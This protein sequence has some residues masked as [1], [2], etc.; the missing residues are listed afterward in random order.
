MTQPE[1]A[2]VQ[3]SL[4]GDREAFEELVRR[5]GR[6]VF[7]R[8]FLETGDAHLSEDLTQE[9]FLTAYRSIRQVTDVRGFRAWLLSIAHSVVIDNIRRRSRKKRGGATAG[10]ELLK[11]VPDPRDGP[12]DLAENHDERQR[13]LSVLRS[14]PEEYRLPLTLRYIGGADYESITRQLAL[15][16]G[17][18]RGLLQ[19]GMTMLRDKMKKDK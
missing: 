1:E 19:R 7:S 16:N 9:T 6:M 8:I 3:K 15:S 13:M 14:L 18:L 12:T 10:A 11:F 5:T 17:S 4:S 2:L